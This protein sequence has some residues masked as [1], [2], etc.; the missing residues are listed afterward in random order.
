MKFYDCYQIRVGY[1]SYYGYC[2][3]GLFKQAIVHLVITAH[4][5]SVSEMTPLFKQ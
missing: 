3:V 2:A 4:S 1:I 5:Q